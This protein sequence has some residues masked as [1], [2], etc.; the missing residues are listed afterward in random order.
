TLARSF[1]SDAIIKNIPKRGYLFLVP[2]IE[3]DKNENALMSK[4][5]ASQQPRVVTALADSEN[6]GRVPLTR[7]RQLRYIAVLLFATVSIAGTYVV[8]SWRFSSSPLPKIVKYTQL[9][10]DGL[11]KR[12]ALFTDGVHVYFEELVSG[13]AVI[14]EVPING[15]EIVHVSTL[16]QNPQ[17]I[18]LFPGTA[19][20]FVADVQGVVKT[21]WRI[22]L[23]GGSPQPIGAV[24]G[25]DTVWSH[26]GQNVSYTKNQ[27]HTLVVA[28]ADG[29]SARNI[30]SVSP[31]WINFPRWSP[32][33]E[34]IRFCVFNPDIGEG[35]GT[36]ALWE[37]GTDGSHPHPLLPTLGKEFQEKIGSWTPD[38]NNYVFDVLRNGQSEIWSLPE[39]EHWFTPRHYNPTQISNVPI[40]FSGPF[41]SP[42]GKKIIVFGKQH[43][44]E[45]V[46]YDPNTHLFLPYLSGISAG[47]LNFSQDGAWLAYIS[48]PDSTL[49]R[50]KADGQERLQLTFAPTQADSPH[51]S[52]DGE[53]IAYRAALPGH[54]KKIFT[55]SRNGGAPQ[56]VSAQESNEEG[57]PT[58][59]ADGKSL[60]YGELRWHPDKI[61]LHIVNLQTGITST[62][63]GSESLWTPRWS[64]DGRYIVALTSDSDGLMLYDL[65]GRKWTMLVKHLPALN[66]PCWSRHGKYIYFDTTSSDAAIYRIGLH[67]RKLE[68]VVSLTTFPR[69]QS[70]GNWLGLAPDD[71]PLLLREARQLEIYALEVDWSNR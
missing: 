44:G 6:D 36:Y 4:D 45:L 15:G 48:Y 20:L 58:W 25:T 61:A 47:G 2:V 3:R 63:P 50:S 49:W 10:N 34:T 39:N 14:A 1:D 11:D 28:N 56:E 35:N 18:G 55:I 57:V 52:P 7:S 43:H 22:P 67:E 24:L 65:H 54:R 46:R 27:Q 30:F 42:D 66:E 40:S 37:I 71:S 13:K 8:S 31:G 21:L 70:F 60:L 68:R 17:L 51:W 26:D 29:T 12:N 38:G 33:K 16:F 23:P 59:S 32:N 53:W 41:V 19:D 62:V 9:T 69:A 64:P 5:L